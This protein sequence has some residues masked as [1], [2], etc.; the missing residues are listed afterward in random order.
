MKSL[1][2]K[3][4]N[5]PILKLTFQYSLDII[6]FSDKLEERKKYSLANQLLRA[7]TSVGANVWESQSAESKADFIHKLKVADKELKESQYWLLLCHSAPT[8]ATPTQL[9]EQSMEIQ[10]VISSIIISTKKSLK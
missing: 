9:I 2:D 1:F 10:K 3:I 7:G 8:L 4:E 6:A 5:N